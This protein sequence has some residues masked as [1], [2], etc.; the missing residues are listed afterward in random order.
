M[1]AQVSIDWGCLG[2]ALLVELAA[3]AAV[4]CLA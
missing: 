1:N 4:G 3:V 2:R